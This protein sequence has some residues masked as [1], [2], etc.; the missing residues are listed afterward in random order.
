M[1]AHDMSYAAVMARKNEI[2]KASMGI[3]FDD[4]IQSPIAFDYERMMRET[5]YTMDDIV[6]IQRET[7]VGNTPL[8]ELRNLTEAVRKISPPGQRARRSW[9]RTRPPTPRAASRPAAP[10]SAPTRRKRK[11]TRA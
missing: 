4:F 6:R 1:T 5:G 11:A 3:D 10:R 8:F 7:K 2:M 9:S